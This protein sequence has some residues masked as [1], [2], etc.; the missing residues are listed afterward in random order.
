[1]DDGDGAEPPDSPTAI[2]SDEQEDIGDGLPWA[3]IIPDIQESA[4]QGN[5]SDS[6]HSEQSPAPGSVGNNS[7]SESRSPLDLESEDDSSQLYSQPRPAPDNTKSGAK[8]LHNLG[9]NDAI[10]TLHPQPRPTS[11]EGSNHGPQLAT[12]IESLGLIDPTESD[13]GAVETDFGKEHEPND[14]L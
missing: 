8:S 6:E 13:S 2:P 7:G 3:G 5:R 4:S 12:E 1:M 11:E 9:S 14:H 10:G